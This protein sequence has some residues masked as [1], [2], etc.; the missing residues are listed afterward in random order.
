M[1]N[2][3]KRILTISGRSRGFKK[4]SLD[5]VTEDNDRAQQIKIRKVNQ[6]YN[7]GLTTEQNLDKN[8]NPVYVTDMYMIP[9]GDRIKLIEIETTAHQGYRVTLIKANDERLNPLQKV[10]TKTFRQSDKDI[11]RNTLTGR[12]SERT[13]L[14]FWFNLNI[15]D[16]WF[17]RFDCRRFRC[18]WWCCRKNC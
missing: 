5:P 18:S 16:S 4:L 12:T 14:H 9:G 11:W 17:C 2:I 1:F 15:V 10:E 7:L 13:L 3:G 6:G 8:R